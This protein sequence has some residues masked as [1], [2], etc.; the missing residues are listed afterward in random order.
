MHKFQASASA[1]LLGLGL[2]MG[3]SQGT[4]CWLKG[5]VTFQ[6]KP[7]EDGNIVLRPAAGT[8]GASA[9][10][11]LAGGKYEFAKAAGLKAGK[12]LILITAT[13]R[14]YQ[15]I[16][17]KYNIAS[18]LTVDLQGGDNIKDFTLAAGAVT[19][20]PVIKGEKALVTPPK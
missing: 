5:Q 17:N 9:S 3:C 15:Y 14:G 12:Y 2:V 13:N 10:A 11:K 1:I 7:V 18:E 8:P 4:S 19:S 20:A 16:P 6:G